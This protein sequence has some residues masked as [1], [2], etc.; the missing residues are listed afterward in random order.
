MQQEYVESLRK[1]SSKVSISDY[2]SSM[3]VCPMIEEGSSIMSSSTG[4][5]RVK[6]FSLLSEHVAEYSGHI[7]KFERDKVAFTDFFCLSDTRFDLV[8]NIRFLIGN[9]EFIVMEIEWIWSLFFC[10]WSIYLEAFIDSLAR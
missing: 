8:L 6:S 2:N 7:M 4:Q 1:D 5:T 3:I 10:F 9:D